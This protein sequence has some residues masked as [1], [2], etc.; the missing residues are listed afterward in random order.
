MSCLS[1]GRSAHPLDALA[2]GMREAAT[3]AEYPTL[4][5]QRHSTRRGLGTLRTPLATSV[6][7]VEIM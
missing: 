2:D 4:G 5:S 3:L 1:C 6:S 7:W